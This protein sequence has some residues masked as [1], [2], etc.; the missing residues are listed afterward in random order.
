MAISISSKDYLIMDDETTDSE[1][2]HN[3]SCCDGGAADEDG[4]PSGTVQASSHGGTCATSQLCE[5]NGLTVHSR[6]TY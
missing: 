2:S 5:T 4:I 1:C 3:N 6:T